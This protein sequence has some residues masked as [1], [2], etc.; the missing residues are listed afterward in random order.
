MPFAKTLFHA[1]NTN[2]EMMTPGTR[3]PAVMN[4]CGSGA[5]RRGLHLRRLDVVVEPPVLDELIESVPG[6]GLLLNL[7]GVPRSS[8][9]VRPERDGRRTTGTLRA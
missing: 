1:L 4:G 6:R 2:G 3:G 5:F 9:R 7:A 8:S